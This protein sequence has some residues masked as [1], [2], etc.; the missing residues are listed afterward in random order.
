MPGMDDMARGLEI[1]RGAMQTMSE[2]YGARGLAAAAGILIDNAKT[3][4]LQATFL[5][6]PNPDPQISVPFVVSTEIL[7]LAHAAVVASVGPGARPDSP[8]PAMARYS[9]LLD[10][11]QGAM[12]QEQNQITALRDRMAQL[13]REDEAAYY[14]QFRAHALYARIVTYKAPSSQPAPES[15]A[16]ITEDIIPDSQPGLSPLSPAME[17]DSSGSQAALRQISTH[18]DI[19]NR[20][21]PPSQDAEF[22]W[23]ATASRY[24]YPQRTMPEAD[25]APQNAHEAGMPTG[26][27]VSKNGALEDSVRQVVHVTWTAPRV[28]GVRKEYFAVAKGLVT[29]TFCGTLSQVQH[30]WTGP[31]G[32]LPMYRSFS[33]LRQAQRWLRKQSVTKQVL[34]PGL[35]ATLQTKLLLSQRLAWSNLQDIQTWRREGVPQIDFVSRLA[36]LLQNDHGLLAEEANRKANTLWAHICLYRPYGAMT[37]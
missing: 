33:T 12:E 6:Y 4:E 37:D 1:L 3:L 9:D 5:L 14:D 20:P 22:I 16:E 8:I 28:A 10:D 29:G 26:A 31:E 17:V 25:N 32:M 7:E 34:V 30:F 21:L 35:P 13:K 24:E 27:S 23:N 11:V 36:G 2:R 15:L 19:K 18:G